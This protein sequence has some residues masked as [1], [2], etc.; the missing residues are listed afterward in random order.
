MRKI[1]L[2]LAALAADPMPPS[3]L[4]GGGVSGHEL[5]TG[6][7]TIQDLLEVKDTTV[8]K[9]GV[10]K[11][12]EAVLAD[13][14]AHRTIVNGLVDEICER[15]TE[16][17]EVYGTSDSGEMVELDETG[18]PPSQ[19]LTGGGEVAYPL[20][21]FG[22][23][24][25]WDA[26][27]FN[28]ATPA[29]MAY[30][31]TQIEASHVNAIGGYVSRALFRGTNYIERDNFRDK[32]P[33]PV[34][35]LLNAD[36]SQIP[37]DPY[38]QGFDGS[39][40]SHYDAIDWA[41]ATVPQREARIKALVNNVVE[42]GHTLGV[43]LYIN[44]SNEDEVTALPG[45]K[46]YQDPRIR[47]GANETI[48]TGTLDI[49]KTNNRAI[50]LIAG[51]EVWVKPWVPQ[52]YQF[53]FAAGDRRRPLKFREFAE[54][55]RQG[56]KLAAKFHAHPIYADAYEAYFGVGAHT[57][58]NGAVLYTGGNIYAPPAITPYRMAGS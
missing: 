56:L 48:A 28:R 26:D 38:G 37:N 2:Y 53:C 39:T 55:A 34:K 13:L 8:F 40:H 44:L 16:R 51:A 12:A 49:T 7:L 36:S 57:R 18:R 24:L 20:R 46:P 41:A 58:T 17:A 5:K 3:L 14:E 50:G 47:A 1:T 23:A 10:D 15:T 35:A 9:Y 42:H 54:A 30:Q 27:Y 32:K 21:K 25:G 4:R 22:N 45:F 43:R 33:L 29:E 19:M 52:N 31:L 11:M 6:T